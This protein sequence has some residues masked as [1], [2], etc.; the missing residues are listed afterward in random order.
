VILDS[1][2]S[3]QIALTASKTTNDMDV[4]VDYI[5]S[6]TQGLPTKGA[7]SRSNSNGTNDVVILAAPPMNFIS[8]VTRISIYNK[9]TAEKIAIVKT[10][11]GS[12][13][14]I[15]IRITI[16]TLRSAIWNANT[17]WQIV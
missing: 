4:K 14:Y 1:A 17:D 8:E 12:T 10:D 5:Q 11:N 7:Y 13:E 9:D 2:I 3:L 6:N 16:P 15:D